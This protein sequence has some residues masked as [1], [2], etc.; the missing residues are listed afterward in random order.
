MRYT[1]F[2]FRR[3][4]RLEDNT[5]L[6][7]AMNSSDNVLP[8]FIFDEN[9]LDELP[10]NDPRV[11]FIYDTLRSLNHRLTEVKSSILILK[12]KPLEVWKELI[13][14]PKR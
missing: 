5:A 3:D 6:N 13:R 14:K 12:G 4:L 8:L 2:W 7:A 9:I 1:L 11:N 10:E